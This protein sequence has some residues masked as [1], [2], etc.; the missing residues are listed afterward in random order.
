MSAEA[1]LASTISREELGALLERGHVGEERAHHPLRPVGMVEVGGGRLAEVA[2]RFGREQ[3]RSLSTLHQTPIRFEFC[4]WEEASLRHYASAMLAT[5]RVARVD[6]GRGNEVYVVLSRPLVFGW[7]MLAFGAR[8]G[9]AIESLPARPYTRIEERFIERAVD[10]ISRT[11]AKVLS[12]EGAP[13]PAL[14]ELEDPTALYGRS[15]QQYRILGFDVF[16][17]GE[18]SVLRIALPLAVM[19]EARLEQPARN[20]GTR[21]GE[22]ADHLYD[23]PVTLSVELGSIELSL[24]DIAHLA[25]GDE[26][27]IQ[28]SHDGGVVV[29]VED[30]EKFRA[31]T[32]KVGSRLAVRLTGEIHS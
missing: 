28:P 29:K 24:S 30:S 18:P 4:H 17:F 27:K 21:T 26:L 6:L 23:T 3:G 16:G 22:V 10:S 20:A 8:P 15:K 32:G 12:A 5:D 14:L 9:E 25:V 31:E 13:Q 1:N 11:F 19:G 7:M 2:K